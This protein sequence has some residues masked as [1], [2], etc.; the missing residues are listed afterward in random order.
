MNLKVLYQNEIGHTLVVVNFGI[1]RESRRGAK[2]PVTF[3]N[4]VSAKR[5]LGLGQHR[6]LKTLENIQL[7]DF[8][9][10]SVLGLGTFL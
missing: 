5:M 2:D 9:Y 6:E 1:G 10:S 8:C 7:V 4:F 3:V